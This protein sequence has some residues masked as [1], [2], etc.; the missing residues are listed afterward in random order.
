MPSGA[1]GPTRARLKHLDSARQRSRLTRAYAALSATRL[2]R[3]I[4]AT[5][6]WKIDRYPVRANRTIPIVQLSRQGP[7]A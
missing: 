7:P 5:I 3:L 6:A 2:G 1:R 4:A